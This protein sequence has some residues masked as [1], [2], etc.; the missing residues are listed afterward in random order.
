MQNSPAADIIRGLLFHRDNGQELS[1]EIKS[2]IINEMRKAGSLAYARNTAIQLFDAMMETLERVE[3]K[4][5][6]NERLK[7]LLRLLKL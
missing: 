3:A 7:A 2:Y 4:L 5:G 1:S 6:P